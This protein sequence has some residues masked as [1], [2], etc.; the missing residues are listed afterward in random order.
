MR[1]FADLQRICR[2]L[3]PYLGSAML[4]Q[5]NG[6]M[7]WRVV[8][9]ELKE[10]NKPATVNR[11]LATIRSV[12]RMSVMSGRIRAIRAPIAETGA[13]HRTPSAEDTG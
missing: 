8:Q 2:L 13:G 12:L 1:S 6:D 10:G 7:I 3:D 4:N 5:I 11:Y 9:G